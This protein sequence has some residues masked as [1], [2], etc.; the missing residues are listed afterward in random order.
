[1]LGKPTSEV[2]WSCGWEHARARNKVLTYQLGCRTL[3][4]PHLQVPGRLIGSS[5]V[6][7]E[8]CVAP[9]GELELLAKENYKYWD[10]LGCGEQ[11]ELADFEDAGAMRTSQT[12]E[13]LKSPLACCIVFL[14]KTSSEAHGGRG[15]GS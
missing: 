1:M 6:G 11:D 10:S 8:C 13:L 12:M 2:Q 4:R 3:P 15:W 7:L 14:R 5:A 9:F